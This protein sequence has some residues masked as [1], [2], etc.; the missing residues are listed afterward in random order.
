MQRLRKRQQRLNV[1]PADADIVLIVAGCTRAHKA[2][3]AAEEAALRDG[4]RTGPALRVAAVGTSFP[5]LRDLRWAGSDEK[6]FQPEAVLS[7]SHIPSDNVNQ[8]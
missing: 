8:W 7:F 5:F 6:C 4:R 2:F 1:T 3:L